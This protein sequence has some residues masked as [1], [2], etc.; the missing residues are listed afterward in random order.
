[1]KRS[2]CLIWGASSSE[3]STPRTPLQH[4]PPPPPPSLPTPATAVGGHIIADEDSDGKA[5]EK[6]Q[7]PDDG[8]TPSEEFL[9][10]RRLRRNVGPEGLRTDPLTPRTLSQP[11]P[12]PPP[13]PRP[14]PAS[15]EG[16]HALADLPGSL[17]LKSTLAMGWTPR[18]TEQELLEQEALEEAGLLD[19]DDDGSHASTEA[20]RQA[21]AA[22]DD[23]R[24]EVTIMMLNGDPLRT[25]WAAPGMSIARV[26]SYLSRN[27]PCIP[28]SQQQYLCEGH[29]Q[30]AGPLDDLCTMAMLNLPTVLTLVRK[31]LPDCRLPFR[32][33]IMDGVYEEDLLAKGNSMRNGRIHNQG[34]P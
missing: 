22:E 8:G 9:E 4:Q 25:V 33:P 18:Y 31:H 19:D 24:Y 21:A 32:R 1:M 15:N 6:A 26:K 13:P 10:G 28:T 27:P 20:R 3:S 17:L 23:E 14:T 7:L 5:L 2:T 16:G 30:N 11:Q 12:P 34:V 29:D